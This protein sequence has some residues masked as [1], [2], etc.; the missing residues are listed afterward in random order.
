MAVN[1]NVLVRGYIHS[2]TTWTPFLSRY[3]ARYISLG[4]LVAVARFAVLDLENICKN[5]AIKR[6]L[7]Y[8][9]TDLLIFSIG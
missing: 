3:I 6:I 5:P 8:D 7:N 9:I 1:Y 2:G 4:T